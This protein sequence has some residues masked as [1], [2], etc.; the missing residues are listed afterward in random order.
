[1]TTLPFLLVPGLNANARVYRDVAE[2]LWQFGPVM[3]A[4][5]LEGEGIGGIADRIL[6]DAP[7]EFALAGFSFGGYLAF[8]ILRRAPQRVRK[9]ALIDTTAR[10]DAGEATEV[11][12]QRIAQTKSGKFGLVVQQSFGSSVHPDHKEH[13][14]LWAVHTAMSMANG[15]EVY[16]RHQEAIIARQ[17]S[18]PLLSA[19]AMPTVVIVGE[20]DAITPPEVAWEMHNAI[21]GS[22]LLV[23]PEAGHLAL[24]EQSARVVEALREWAA[25]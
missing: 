23:I 7:P 13:G 20:A 10:P 15:P 3:V 21:T 1:M 9:L 14:E 6:A 11:R 16:A 24:L 5:H 25:A 2:A 22:R 4:N 19:I 18:R 17:D 12:R 8:E